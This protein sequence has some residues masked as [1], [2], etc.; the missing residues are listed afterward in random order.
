V[1]GGRVNALEGGRGDHG[2][3]WKVGGAKFRTAKTLKFEKGG[4]SFL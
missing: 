4:A 1:G 3:D 2:V